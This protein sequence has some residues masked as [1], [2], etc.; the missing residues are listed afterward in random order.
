MA[1][2]GPN[3]WKFVSPKYIVEQWQTEAEC[4]GSFYSLELDLRAIIAS[5][6]VQSQDKLLFFLLKRYKTASKQII[7]ELLH[8]MIKGYVFGERLDIRSDLK[9]ISVYFAQINN[10]LADAVAESTQMCCLSPLLCLALF[11]FLCFGLAGDETRRLSL[12]IARR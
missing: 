11:N 2:A 6:G 3:S 5:W 12:G 9:V 7:L 4:C 10:V 8:D 1:R